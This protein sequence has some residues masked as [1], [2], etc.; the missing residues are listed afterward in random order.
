MLE[1]LSIVVP[2]FNEEKSIIAFYQEVILNIK[3]IKNINYEIIFVNDGSVDQSWEIIKQLQ[4]DDANI[5]GL[6]FSRNFGK[7]AAML[8]GLKHASGDYIVVMDC[9]LQHPPS[10]L[11]RM[12]ELIRVN[13]YDAVGAYRNGRN[14]G[15]RTLYAKLFYRFINKM[16]D[17]KIKQNAT[18][19]RMMKKKVVKALLSLPEFNRFSKGLFE[20]V[21]FKTAYIG[22]DD[23]KRVEGKSTWNFF[24]LF[25]YALQGITSFSTVPLKLSGILGFFC[26]LI[27][28]LYMIYVI[29]DRIVNGTKVSGWATIVSLILFLGGIILISLGLLGEYIGRIYNETKKRP[30]YIIDEIIDDE[31]ER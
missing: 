28:F 27:S 15:V 20:W 23:V 18:D 11:S 14:K 19:F 6:N 17:I 26:A 8:A 29:I 16:S 13:G 30:L 21:G 7:E 10:I 9:D 3:E 31:E 24:K 12:L 1:K 5:K 4:S 25:N 22:Y 2:C